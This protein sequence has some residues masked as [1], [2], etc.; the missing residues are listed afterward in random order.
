M[1][2]SL[3]D[4]LKGLSPDQI[5]KLLAS[6]NKSGE[7]KVK[8][9]FEKM[10]RTSNE[11]YPLSKAQ[12][13]IWFLSYLFKNTSLYNI[14]IAVKLQRDV[15]IENLKTALQQVVVQNEILRTTFHEENGTV[16]QKIHSSY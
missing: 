12:E 15:S 16:F 9:E 3:K 14:P 11:K 4:K 7:K 1:Q 2:D 13:R 5:R 8:K 10:P 6:R